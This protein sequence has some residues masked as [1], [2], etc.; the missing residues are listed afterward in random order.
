MLLSNNVAK[1][2]SISERNDKNGKL[3]D[4]TVEEAAMQQSETLTTEDI[5]KLELLDNKLQEDPVNSMSH[6]EASKELIQ[7]EEQL[8]R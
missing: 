3:K 4:N 7:L 6:L 8:K 5:E 2:A 1:I